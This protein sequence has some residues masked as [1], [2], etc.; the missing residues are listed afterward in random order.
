MVKGFLALLLVTILPAISAIDAEDHLQRGELPLGNYDWALRY[1]KE[2]RRILWRAWEPDVVLRTVSFPPF[3]T[4]WIVGIVRRPGSYRAFLLEPT[5]QVWSALDNSAIRK[6]ELTK[7]HTR[8]YDRALDE[9]LVER[10]AAIFR[11]VLGNRRNYLEDRRILN[12]S[13]IFIYML[14]YRPGEYIIANTA[15]DEHIPSATLFDVSAS[16]YL[17]IRGKID[18]T[19]KRWLR[20]NSKES[21]LA[22]ERSIWQ[23]ERDLKITK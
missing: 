19:D 17:F 2:V 20:M 22:L 9:K 12:D 5:T 4:E 11:N 1:D 13:S 23:A 16:L 8:Y 10:L 21:L 14:R 18:V 6:T 7:I 3:R 15:S